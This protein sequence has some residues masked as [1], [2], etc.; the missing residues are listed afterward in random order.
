VISPDQKF[1]KSAEKEAII[2]VIYVTK[3]TGER[4]VI[5]TDSLSTLM[6]IEGDIN[7]ENQKKNCHSGKYWTKKDTLL[8]VPGHMIIQGNE[9]ADEEAKAGRRPLSHRKIPTTRSD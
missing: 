5:I 8:W 9:I 2:K 3:R 6:A 7:S 1:R 4:R